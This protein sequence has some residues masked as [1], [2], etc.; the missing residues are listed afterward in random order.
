MAPTEQALRDRVAAEEAKMLEI[1]KTPSRHLELK[2]Q[3]DAVK[4]ARAELI[5]YESTHV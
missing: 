3:Q 2:A 1:R 5:A 4:K